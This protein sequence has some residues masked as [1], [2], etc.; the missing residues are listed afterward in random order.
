MGD[1][2][3]IGEDGGFDIPTTAPVSAP[4]I[5]R[6]R[7]QR[8]SPENAADAAVSFGALLQ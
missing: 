3:E 2:I 1:V 4:P 5:L 7:I 8:R 6:G